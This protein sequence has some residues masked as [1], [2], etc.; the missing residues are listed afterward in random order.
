[1]SDFITD[2]TGIKRPL[3]VY[4]H[5]LKKTYYKVLG[6]CSHSETLEP[7]VLYQATYDT[8]RQWVRPLDMFFEDVEVDGEKKPRFQF[9]K[10]FAED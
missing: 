3:G 6:I 1:M 9:I 4:Q 10:P 7:L 8:C 2:A 5:Y